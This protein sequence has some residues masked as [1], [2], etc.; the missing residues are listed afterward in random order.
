MLFLSS[1][2][3]VWVWEKEWDGEGEG[4]WP[5]EGPVVGDTSAQESRF[6]LS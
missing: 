6:F 4:E 3:P 1:F 2:S 5:E